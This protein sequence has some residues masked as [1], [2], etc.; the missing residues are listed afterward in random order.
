MNNAPRE[1]AASVDQVVV[2]ARIM[3]ANFFGRMGNVKFDRPTA[4]RS[5]VYEE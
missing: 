1:D 5:E 2:R 3:L 4:A